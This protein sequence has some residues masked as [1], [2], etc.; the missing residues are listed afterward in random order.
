[1]TCCL[2][3]IAGIV[4]HLGATTYVAVRGITPN[5]SGGAL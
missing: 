1:M 5:M 2:Q 3:T 4:Y